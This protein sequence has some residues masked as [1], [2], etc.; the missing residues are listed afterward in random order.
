[1]LGHAGG[2]AQAARLV[3]GEQW[4]SRH[5]HVA[6]FCMPASD[7]A[8]HRGNNARVTLAGAG[9]TAIGR[10]RI[11]IGLGLVER[12]LTDEFLL[13]QLLVAF[14]IQFRHGVLCFCR[15]GGFTSFAGV[16]T[17]Q[18]VA[19]ADPLPRVGAYLGDAAGDLGPDRRLHDC[20]ND[21]FGGKSQVDRMR[22]D[23]DNR[24]GIGRMH[25]GR[26]QSEGKNQYGQDRLHEYKHTLIHETTA[27]RLSDPDHGACQTFRQR[28]SRIRQLAAAPSAA[29]KV[30]AKTPFCQVATS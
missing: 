18:Q 15:P 30:T 12:R 14:V 1:M 20:L 26:H 24:Q 8:G 22:L 13:F 23:D 6:G 29:H 4:H 19:L 2:D 10:R 9:G 3:N 27:S 5:R 17:H 21:R 11:E 16:D 25:G 7:D 28:V